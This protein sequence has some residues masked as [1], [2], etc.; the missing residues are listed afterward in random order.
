MIKW[1][2]AA[3]PAFIILVILGGIITVLLH[4]LGMM[5]GMR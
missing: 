3:I 1:A 4:G 5:W 2:I